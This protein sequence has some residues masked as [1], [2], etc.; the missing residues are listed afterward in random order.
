[1][2]CIGLD[3]PTWTVSKF[4]PEALRI[5]REIQQRGKLPIL[6]GGTLYYIQSLLVQ[7]SLVQEEDYDD[8]SAVKY[9]IL[10]ESTDVILDKLREV[11]P[12]IVNRWH[13][14]D[15]R[16]IQRSLEIWLKTGKRAS[17]VYAEQKKQLES[18]L[19]KD[20]LNAGFDPLVFWIH[21]K[22]DVLDL[23]LHKRVVTMVD[24]GL[25]DE[26]KELSQFQ[27]KLEAEQ[28][29]HDATKGIWIS[30]GYKE[31][32]DHTRALN[33][34]AT[35][36]ELAELK[37]KAI[38]RTQISTH[39]YAKYQ[40]KWI[41]NKLLKA[42]QRSGISSVYLLDGSDLN[43]W[44]ASVS[45]R[46]ID[47]T[48][49]FLKGSEIPD[50]VEFASPFEDELKPKGEDLSYNQDQWQKKT[51][52]H[53]HVVAITPSDWEKHITGNKHKRVLAGKRKRSMVTLPDTITGSEID[54]TS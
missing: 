7:E 23:R 27:Y 48:D 49:S 53:C 30:I 35:D 25:L 36:K 4:V 32:S 18:S 10:D 31:F 41:R 9:P 40:H 15:R 54:A 44:Q 45:D 13:P 50:P 6:V 42:L 14:S 17:D 52:E 26:V 1:L 37:Q 19:P 12:V 28:N 24:S 21:A 20:D 8:S 5:S 38:E 29:H 47:V 46:A 11:D 34:G 22:K 51:C 3:E 43:I 2:A 33:N 16:K 39:Q